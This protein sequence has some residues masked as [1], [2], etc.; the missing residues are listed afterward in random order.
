MTAA[1]LNPAYIPNEPASLSHPTPLQLEESSVS[2]TPPTD[3]AHLIEEGLSMTVANLTLDDT[4][5]SEAREDALEVTSAAEH[6]VANSRSLPSVRKEPE[7]VSIPDGSSAATLDAL[8]DLPHLPRPFDHAVPLPAGE[9]VPP[10]AADEDK[11]TM[12]SPPP[13]RPLTPPPIGVDVFSLSGVPPLQTFIP[14]SL[15]PDDLFVHDP[16]HIIERCREKLESP[17]DLPLRYVRIFP[18]SKGRHE[19][20]P[21]YFLPLVPDLKPTNQYF[22]PPPPASLNRSPADE[23]R[24]AHLYLKAHNRLSQGHHSSVFAAPLRLRLDPGSQEE[25][26]VRIAAKTAPGSC[27][28][29]KMLHLEAGVYDAFPRYLMDDQYITGSRSS[30][31]V[32]WVK[33]AVVPKF[34][35]YYAAVGADGKPI[36]PMHLGCHS[37]MTCPVSWPTRILLVEECGRPILPSAFTPDQR[38]D[39]LQL[40]ERLH[41]AG[42]AQNSM[43]PRN[44][45]VQPGPLRAPP[46]ARSYATPSFRIIDFGRGMALSHLPPSIHWMF[47]KICEGEEWKA[48]RQILGFCEGWD[49]VRVVAA[50]MVETLLCHM[51]V[52]LMSMH[53]SKLERRWVLQAEPLS[54]GTGRQ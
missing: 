38:F 3:H 47:A 44:V 41:A 48:A 45:L 34:Y 8:I 24:V 15:F 13:E 40:V 5:S 49:H 39:C 27:G 36:M 52:A 51:Y 31:T 37:D 28:T 53:W 9:E 10:P 46:A 18:N 50:S 6:D 7:R 20:L 42:F 23:V 19:P 25:S 30:V 16:D 4:G 17:S 1:E 11:A 22:M 12:A 33:P 26:T 43:H 54:Y 35:G 32:R 29:H 2:P 14:D 21:D